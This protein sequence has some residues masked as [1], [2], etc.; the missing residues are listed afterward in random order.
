MSGFGPFESLDDYAMWESHAKEQEAYISC[1]GTT[2]L[3]SALIDAGIQWWDPRG[4]R[5]RWLATTARSEV[6]SRGHWYWAAAAWKEA[7][8]QGLVKDPWGNW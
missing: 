1:P 6:G 7:I 4:S 2:V 3:E 8:T 5:V